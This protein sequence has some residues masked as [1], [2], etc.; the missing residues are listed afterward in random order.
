MSLAKSFL[1]HAR[2][3]NLQVL[4]RPDTLRGSNAYKNLQWAAQEHQTRLDSKAQMVLRGRSL[5]TQPLKVRADSAVSPLKAARNEALYHE[6][7]EALARLDNDGERA[8]ALVP[9][10]SQALTHFFSGV[11]EYAHADLP[12][13]NGDYLRIDRSVGRADENYVWYESDMTG[14]ARAGST[15]SEKDIDL[16]GGPT[17]MGNSGNIVPFL[18]G[19]ATNFM[20]LRR[21]AQAKANGKPDFKIEQSKIKACRRVLATA[22]N[23][24]WLYGDTEL[25]IDGL[26][27]HPA[28]GT[29]SIVGTWASKTALQILDDLLAMVTVVENTTQ[30]QLGDRS[31][32]KI[33][34]PPT[35][36]DK[37]SSLPITASGNESVLSYF[38]RTQRLK[39]EQVV[40]QFD[41]ASANSQIWIG[42]PLGLARDRALIVYDQQ[43]DLR[44]PMFILSQD[45]EIPAPPRPGMTETTFFHVRAGGCKVPDSRGIRFVEGL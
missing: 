31:R 15:Y 14:V 39:E 24:M 11:M 5:F 16:V 45:I 29:L 41:L 13:W 32:L 40:K 22:V 2:R 10:A 38:L 9:Q 6:W 1:D 44:D 30:G 25:G 27:N 36:F 28:I 37:A 26:M 43:D 20:D 4:G 42:G 33:F 17:G 35:Q 19:M 18:V 23:F 12:A 8:D 34:L 7:A 3:E 21:S